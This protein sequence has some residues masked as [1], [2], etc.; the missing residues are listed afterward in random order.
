MSE[1]EL[2]KRLNRV[3]RFIPGFFLRWYVPRLLRQLLREG[4]VTYRR[5]ESHD[6]RRDRARFKYSLAYGE[7]ALVTQ[8]KRK[9]D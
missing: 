5:S 4:R 2:C 6:R 8:R 3:L 1:Q 7:N 9:F